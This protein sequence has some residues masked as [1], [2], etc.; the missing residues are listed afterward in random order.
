[1]C[2]MFCIWFVF[3]QILLKLQCNHLLHHIPY[4]PDENCSN[5][6]GQAMAPLVGPTLSRPN[7][8]LE[9]W[10]NHP[11][12]QG[13]INHH[14]N[15]LPGNLDQPGGGG[16][17]TDVAKLI[18]TITMQTCFLHGTIFRLFLRSNSI[19]QRWKTYIRWPFGDGFIMPEFFILLFEYI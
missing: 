11:L 13:R 10:Q 12:T 6:L 14:P 17:N 15:P 1:M 8:N 16:S 3:I 18:V 5:W 4:K 19:D 7:C 2:K 9:S